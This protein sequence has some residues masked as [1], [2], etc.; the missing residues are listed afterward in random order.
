MVVSSLLLPS[1]V[2]SLMRD[3]AGMLSSGFRSTSGVYEQKLTRPK[4]EP[5][6]KSAAKRHN[7]TSQPRYRI[8]ATASDNLVFSFGLLIGM[9]GRKEHKPTSSAACHRCSRYQDNRFF[10]DYC[11]QTGQKSELKTDMRNVTAIPNHRSNM[12]LRGL[13]SLLWRNVI[14]PQYMTVTADLVTFHLEDTSEF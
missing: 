13:K 5:H 12:I 11:G 6:S 10:Q 7:D 8:A 3:A 1:R 14:V 4:A 2:D 9:I